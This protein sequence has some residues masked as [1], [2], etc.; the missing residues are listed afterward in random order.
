[1]NADNDNVDTYKH[2]K[3]KVKDGLFSSL[4][5]GKDESIPMVKKFSLPMNVKP[6]VNWNK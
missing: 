3:F 2:L 4:W 1:M 6:K 5:R